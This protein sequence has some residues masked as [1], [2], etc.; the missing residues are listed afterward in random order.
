MG[1]QGASGASCAHVG[2]SRSGATRG[3]LR[4]L[5]GHPVAFCSLFR[6]TA[7]AAYSVTL[8][9]VDAHASIGAQA[10]WAAMVVG[11]LAGT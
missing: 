2:L 4:Q 11:R 5:L 1:S 6:D 7:R 10:N 3:E 8:A 9:V